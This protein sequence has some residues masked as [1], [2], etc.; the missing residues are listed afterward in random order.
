MK[1]GIVLNILGEATTYGPGSRSV[2]LMK[3]CPLRCVWCNQVEARSVVPQISFDK[4]KCF[5]CFTC[6]TACKS[7]AH[8]VN[9]DQHCFNHEKCR[10]DGYCVKACP[11]DAV[12]IKGKAMSAD[13]LMPT[14]LEMSDTENS[15]RRNLTLSG[16]EPMQ[17]FE[18][19]KELL[20]LARQN[21]FH[22]CL[23]TS[24]YSSQS[25][26]KEI[27]PLVDLFLFDYKETNPQRHLEFVGVKQHLILANL[28]LLVEHKK[29]VVLRCP[30]VPGY[31]DHEEHF[32]G[33][34]R[35]ATQY[36]L[37]VTVLPYEKLDLHKIELY[38][39]DTPMADIAAEHA[40]VEQ[41][42][43]LLKDKGCTVLEENMLPVKL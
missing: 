16:G 36:D 9:N 12:S 14:I 22:T 27:A 28:K 24:G 21:G 42:L 20:T 8:S 15:N 40:T 18:F 33:I 41:W 5:N 7:G 34:A 39:I 29:S 35:I 6:L 3:G 38:G 11:Y 13:E 25:N 26:F 2:I 17:Q 1:K 30:I 10:A 37:P 31:N 23:D 4:D 43:Y 32:E 19:S